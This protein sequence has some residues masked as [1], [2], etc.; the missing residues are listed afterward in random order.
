MC[1]K[2]LIGLLCSKGEE[3]CW[4]RAFGD[5]E[6]LTPLTLDEL[7]RYIKD[8]VDLQ[9]LRPGWEVAFLRHY[10][11]SVYN[12]ERIWD[13]FPEEVLLSPHGDQD[14]AYND[15]W[16]ERISTD[17][18]RWMQRN[19]RIIRVGDGGQLDEFTLK[20]AIEYDNERPAVIREDHGHPRF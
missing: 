17:I 12:T 4:Q 5:K 18:R 11:N 15:V 16:A 6:G 7:I 10:Y 19:T 14:T 20:E 13:Y 1:G 8:E 2:G 3:G 9:G